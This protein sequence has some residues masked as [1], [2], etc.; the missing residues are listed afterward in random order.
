[1][2]KAVHTSLY[3]VKRLSRHVLR[4]PLYCILALLVVIFIDL[5]VP[6]RITVTVTNRG[7]E[8]LRGAVVHVTGNA[9]P[10]G[11][12]APGERKSVFVEPQ[13]ESDVELAFEPGRRLTIGCYLEP[14]YQ[15][16]VTA[17]VTADRVL[18]DTCEIDFSLF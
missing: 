7:S 17:E 14:G 6:A 16:L 4:L 12:L 18:A 8:P 3:R 1:M 9:Y 10:I 13:G 11:Y 5:A 2:T 15:A